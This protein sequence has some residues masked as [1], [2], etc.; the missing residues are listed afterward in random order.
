MGWYQSLGLPPYT[1]IQLVKRR[2]RQLAKKHH[3]DALG[4]GPGP[5][6]DGKM[7]EI[8]LAYG[9]IVRTYEEKFEMTASV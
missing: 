3:P 6:N 1:P 7:K 8:N 2:Y 4:A 5:K 9:N